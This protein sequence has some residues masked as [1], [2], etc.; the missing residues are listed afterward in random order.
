VGK[1]TVNPNLD[2]ALN[3]SF[4]EFVQE[5]FLLARKVIETP[6]TWDGWETSNPYRDIVDTN[7]L[8]ESGHIHNF[9]AS[10]NMF[11][12]TV[13]WVTDYVALV[14]FGYSLSDGR[15]IPSRK[16]AEI[17]VYENDLLLLASTILIKHFK[18]YA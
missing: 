2:K 5:Y 4:E 14:Y 12:A 15:R 17:A 10:E 1:F 9:Q 18:K 11:S 7:D 16:W 8:N 6:R 3:Q 13:T